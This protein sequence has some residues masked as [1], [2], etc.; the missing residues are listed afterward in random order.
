MPGC[1]TLLNLDSLLVTDDGRLRLCDYYRYELQTDGPGDSDLR[2]GILA[3][4]L[5]MYQLLSGDCFPS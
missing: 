4:G 1:P 5:I 2:I 3:T